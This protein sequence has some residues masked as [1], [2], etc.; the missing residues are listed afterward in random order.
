MITSYEKKIKD[1]GTGI[2]APIH[3]ININHSIPNVPIMPDFN[4]PDVQGNIPTL[5]K[6]IPIQPEFKSKSGIVVI[7][8][9]ILG[10][11]AG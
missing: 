8:L 11:L 3:R 2:L 6:N 5:Q 10:I 7:A 4:P 1:S 9:I